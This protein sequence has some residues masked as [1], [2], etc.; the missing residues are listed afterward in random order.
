[1]VCKG[2]ILL[3]CSGTIGVSLL[4]GNSYNG[5]AISQHPARTRARKSVRG[6]LHAYLSTSFGREV[7][8][9]Q[10]YGKGIKELT[11]D[12]IK[13]VL[14]P[15][16]DEPQLSKI[17]AMMLTAAH[18]YDKARMRLKKADEELCDIFGISGKPDEPNLWMTKT[19]RLFSVLLYRSLMNVLILIFMPWI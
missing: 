3:S 10:N 9:Q 15:V 17:N 19:I 18:R 13:L 2:E 16:V 14:V 7:V 8:L 12:Q 1:M 5:F 6:Y 11:E 4:C